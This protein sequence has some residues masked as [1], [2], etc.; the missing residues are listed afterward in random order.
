M[1]RGHVAR[2][3]ADDPDLAPIDRPPRPPPRALHARPHHA[4]AGPLE[5]APP[6]PARP[7]ERPV[8]VEEIDPH[9]WARFYAGRPR[10]YDID[11][12]WTR[13]YRWPRSPP[14]RQTWPTSRSS[15]AKAA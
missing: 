13:C 12:P 3:V 6:G 1:G 9:V 15:T 14:E 5:G 11:G 4:R 10:I 8:D 7:D 2:R